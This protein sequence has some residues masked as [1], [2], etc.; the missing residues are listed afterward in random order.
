MHSTLS[1]VN[2]QGCL[3]Y[4]EVISIC[5]EVRS[6]SIRL[7]G[8]TRP[9][10][11]RVCSR[12]TS[13]YWKRH[14]KYVYRSQSKFLWLVALQCLVVESCISAE[15]VCRG[16]AFCSAHQTLLAFQ[17]CK[18]ESFPRH[19]PLGHSH[20]NKGFCIA[21]IKSAIAIPSRAGVEVMRS[22][23]GTQL[24]WSL[25]QTRTYCNSKSNCFAIRQDA[26][27]TRQETWTCP[28]YWV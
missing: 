12:W 8:W 18:V 6:R 17:S 4:F 22:I 26:W 10:R 25:G 9:D 28:H 15:Y 16:R 1:N 3:I 27:Q 20:L 2:T 24:A 13:A 19:Q 11:T 23:I 5:L 7:L 21:K 14:H